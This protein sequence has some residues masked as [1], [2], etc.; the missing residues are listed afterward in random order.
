MHAHN[1][2]HMFRLQVSPNI[3]LTYACSHCLSYNSYMTTLC[4]FYLCFLLLNNF[5]LARYAIFTRSGYLSEHWN[6]V[7]QHYRSEHS[8]HMCQ[9]FLVHYYFCSNMAV[10]HV[11]VIFGLKVEDVFDSSEDIN[12]NQRNR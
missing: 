10:V 3:L 8:M 1:G 11:V 9:L 4:N 5:I 7:A 12:E 2:S 6:P